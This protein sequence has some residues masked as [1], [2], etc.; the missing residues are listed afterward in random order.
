MKKK[1]LIGIAGIVMI[2]VAFVIYKISTFSL[3][4]IEIKEVSIIDVPNQDFKVGVFYLP[5]NATSQDFIQVRKIQNDVGNVIGNFERY[6]FVVESELT[7]DSLL[8]IV[9]KDTSLNTV[10]PDTFL[11][12]LR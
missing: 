12:N 8:R 7:G 3:F 2:F 10:K 11:I 9:L 4:D 1:V 6:D 5:S